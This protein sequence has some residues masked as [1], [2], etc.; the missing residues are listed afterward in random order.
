MFLLV[1]TAFSQDAYP[2][3]RMQ[4]L[5]FRVNS[6]QII[7]LSSVKTQIE[8]R[9]KHHSSRDPQESKFE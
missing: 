1:L 4:L 7:N 8:L 2:F 3:L 9:E 5:N 6:D